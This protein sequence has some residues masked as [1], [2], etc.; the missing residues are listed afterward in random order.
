MSG[1]EF[2]AKLEKEDKEQEVIME[3]RLRQEVIKESEIMVDD[4]PNDEEED[5]KEYEGLN[6]K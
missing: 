1:E 4:E 6:E 3:R 5:L 2:E